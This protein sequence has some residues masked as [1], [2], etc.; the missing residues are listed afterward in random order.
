MNKLDL[1]IIEMFSQLTAE[2]K[3]EVLLFIGKNS[4]KQN[5]PSAGGLS[6]VVHD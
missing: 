1:E 6:C 4:T 3:Q 5:S 2:E